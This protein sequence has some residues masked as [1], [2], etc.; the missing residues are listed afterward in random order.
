MCGRTACV[1]DKDTICKRCCLNPTSVGPVIPKWINFNAKHQYVPSYNIAPGS[2]TP[3]LTLGSTVHCPSFKAVIQPM[4]WGLVPS[5]ARDDSATAFA[6][7]NARVESLLVKPAYGSAMRQGKR[8]VVLAQGFYE[9]K[10]V[11]DRKQPYYI[12][13][14]DPKQLLMMAGVFSFHEQKQ[15]F[16][17]SVITTDSVGVVADV[18]HRMPVILNTD[19]NVFAWLDSSNIGANQAYNSLLQLT[20][21]MKSISL[22]IHPVTPRM[23]STAFNEPTCIAPLDET[24]EFKNPVKSLGSQDVLAS[25]LKRAAKPEQDEQP[26]ARKLVAYSNNRSETELPLASD[27][28]YHAC[29]KEPE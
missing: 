27:C 25:F 12:F 4:R 21:Q 5:F 14:S 6:T 23:N 16:S 3:I 18:H 13:P 29:K 24:V 8:C 10:S 20:K 9:W 2:F 28:H 15:L 1:L 7:S 26:V 11:N 19:D 22:S 17:Y